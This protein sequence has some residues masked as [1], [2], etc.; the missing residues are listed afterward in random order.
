MSK[1]RTISILPVNMRDRYSF[2]GLWKLKSVKMGREAG[3]SVEKFFIFGLEGD[4]QMVGIDSKRV[5]E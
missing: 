3:F 2:F 5:R 4:A 1:N